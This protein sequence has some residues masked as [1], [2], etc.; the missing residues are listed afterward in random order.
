MNQY[1]SDVTKYLTRRS[2]R[3]FYFREILQPIMIG[4]ACWQEWEAAGHIDSRVRKQRE[5]KK[6][7]QAIK[8]QCSALVTYFLYHVSTFQRVHNLKQHNQLLVKCS[9]TGAYGDI[10]HS[11]QN[12][13]PQFSYA[14]QHIMIPN[15]FIPISKVAVVF[16]RHNSVQMS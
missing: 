9:N 12:I 15:V 11:R 14:Y 5:N 3:T 16:N 8:H 13:P 7:S 2:L 1:I 10:S 4:N 6:W